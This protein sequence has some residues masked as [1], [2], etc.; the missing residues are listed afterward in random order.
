MKKLSLDIIHRMEAQK[1]EPYELDKA[2]RKQLSRVR[3][4]P[5]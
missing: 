1:S 5:M 3:N 4:N 2:Q